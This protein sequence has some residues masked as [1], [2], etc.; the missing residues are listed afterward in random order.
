[1]E[2]VDHIVHARWLLPVVPRDTLLEEHSLALRDGRI[3]AIAPRPEMAGLFAAPAETT[4]AHQVLLPGLVN[5]HGHFAMTLLRG[6][7]DDHALMEWLQ[8]HI[9]PAEARWVG[10]EFVRAGTRLAIAE[11]LAS[12]TTCASDM[13]FFPDVVAATVI[14][15]GFR[16]QIA[17]PVMDHPSAWAAGAEEYLAKGL[18]VRDDYR[19]NPRLS[20]A[21]GPH[22]PYTNGDA[23]LA[24]IAMLAAE[25]DAPVQMHVHESAGEVRDAIAQHGSRPLARLAAL[26]LLSP[27][28]Q[29]V[30]MTQVAP[31]DLELLARERV[32]VIHCPSSNLKLAAGFCPVH[33]LGG[34]G[35][36]VA[37]GTDGAASNNTLDLFAEL[38][39]AALL[40]KGSSGDPTA[41]SAH[42]ALRMATLGGAEAL[43][44]ADRIGSLEPGKD[45]DMIAVD[46]R[47]L[48]CQ[49]VY[50]VHSALVYTASG[51]AVSHAWIEGRE[52]LAGGN[53]GALDPER[54]HADAALWRDRIAAR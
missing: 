35:I 27:R 32:Q 47:R 23:M 5:A 2:N 22:A 42:A 10:E 30:H 26:G 7:A 54:L 20:F 49:P 52:L 50:D 25:L 13:Y 43:G 21:F 17:F 28:F 9:W 38:R 41:L 6:L 12:G 34:A 8:Q 4:L 3:V 19:G 18:Q 53:A 1:M 40:A 11:M 33:A 51:A 39:L 37:L 45:A 16:A 46:V 48:G 44:L 24:R 15:T 29:A 31:A 14:E 36:N